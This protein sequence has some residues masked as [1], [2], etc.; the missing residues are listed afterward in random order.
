[1]DRWRFDTQLFLKSLAERSEARERVVIAQASMD[2]TSSELVRRI[3]DGQAA[4]GHIVIAGHQTAGR[5]R[6]RHSWHSPPGRNLYISAV[7]SIAEPINQTLPL[8][9]LAAGAAVAKTVHRLAG[10]PARL[11][12]PNDLLLDGR[13]VAGILCEA[14]RVQQRPVLAVVG[15][16][17]NLGQQPFPE[18]LETIAGAVLSD[19]T[20]ETIAAHWIAGLESRLNEMHADGPSKLLDEWRELA[21]PFGRQVRIG[22]VVGTTVGLDDRG[23][24]LVKQEDGMLVPVAGGIVEPFGEEVDR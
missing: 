19:C 15:L 9:P 7:A 24:L 18:E 6:Q 4:A 23:H 22:S 3:L 1:M 16:G 14:P 8:V 12:W 20:I 17:L 11:K 2:S 21:E 13:K 5:G 10:A